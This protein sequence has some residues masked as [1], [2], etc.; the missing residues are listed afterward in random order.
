MESLMNSLGLWLACSVMVIITMIQSFIYLKKA[1]KT[2]TEMG[3][4]KEV[5]MSCIRASAIASIGPS[6][7]IGVGVV[8]LMALLGG[9][10]AWM[11]LS[12]IGAL[13]YEGVTSSMAT[14]ALG[15][16]VQSLT[17]DTFAATVWAM[18]LAGCF[19]Q[20]NVVLF[21]PSYDKILQK[22][23]KGDP[24]V[25]GFIV[26]AAMM[27]IFSRSVVPHFL[28][29]SRSTAAT[30]IGALSYMVLNLVQQK[31]DIKWLREWTL[32][33]AMIAGMFGALLFLRR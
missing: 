25:L 17:P 1:I 9:P 20:L 28:T 12:V 18:C 19:W 8:A 11:R 31:S 23:T 32:P 15:V 3:Y 33:F 24:K 7:A 21:A 10:V 29:I 6:A 22:V 2:A 5:Q 4:S 26:T 14:E 16:T 30:V 13:V 27:A